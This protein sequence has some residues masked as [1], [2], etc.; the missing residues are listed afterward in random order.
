MKFG[1]LVILLL[2]VLFINSCMQKPSVDVVLKPGEELKI[3]MILP[4][5]VIGRYAHTTSTA[6]FAYFLS[7]DYP[8]S[9]K[10]FQ[11][12]DE[13]SEEI[14]RVLDEI[15]AQDI[16]YV[17]APVTLK[18]ARVISEQEDEL[19]LYLPTVHKSDLPNAPQN[20][21]FGAIDYKAQIERLNHLMSS[22]LVIMYDESAQG[23]KLAKM[24][25]AQYLNTQGPFYPTRRSDDALAANKP[26]EAAL[27]PKAKSVIT[28][29]IDKTRSNLKSYL[30]GNDKIQYGS[31][32]LNTP[33]IK[34]SM[35]LSQLSVYDT[36]V[37]NTLSTQINYDPL[38][39]TMTQKKDRESLYIANSISIQ[40]DTIVQ[41]NALLNNDIVYDWINYAATVGAD[42]FYNTITAQERLYDLPMSDN[43]VIYPIAIVQPAG[44]HFKVIESAPLP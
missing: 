42:Y 6:V 38:I 11:I 4:E 25:K 7:R 27:E 8:F 10:T 15:K 28:Y 9:L 21:Y 35:I 31:F 3:A 44:S 43:Q 23:E 16:R 14:A 20:L 24:S 41:A 5:R 39:L 13:S 26:Y 12:T 1:R 37:T 29:G 17:I 40:N 36:A 19:L 2:S 18:G 32:L 33:L 34:S 22:P 30:D